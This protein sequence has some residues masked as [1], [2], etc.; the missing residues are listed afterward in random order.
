M[1]KQPSRDKSNLP[2]LEQRLVFVQFIRRQRCRY[3]R[4]LSRFLDLPPVFREQIVT[5]WETDHRRMKLPGFEVSK[6]P[7][8]K[9][10][11]G[12]RE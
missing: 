7:E 6:P 1:K 2:P 9:R 4:S 12:N 5:K 10:K 11:D 3:N 8:P